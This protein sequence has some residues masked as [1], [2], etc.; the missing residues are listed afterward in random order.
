[1]PYKIISNGAITAN[2]NMFEMT[3]LLVAE[4][5]EDPIETAVSN[6]V[7]LIVA[8]V[9]FEEVQM[10]ELLRSCVLLSVNVPVAVSCSVKPMISELLGA[11]TVIDCRAAAV[12]VSTKVFE[13][14]PLLT[15]VMLVE[16]IPVPVA[17]PVLLTVAAA[18]LEEV[19]IAEL[20]SN[21]VLP[22]LK[23]PVE[24]N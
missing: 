24:V 6:P 3:P 16:P 5:F 17:R 19:Q 12:T 20:V 15:A 14:T 18:V 21:W 1:M 22:S 8:T 7:P 13:V 4:I 11:V 2:A 10:T 23:V 9:A